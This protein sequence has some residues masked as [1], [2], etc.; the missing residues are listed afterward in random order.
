MAEFKTTLS[1]EALA[2][3]LAAL[4]DAEE[5]YAAE[6]P[7]PQVG[8]RPV[9]VLYGGADRFQAETASKMGA[10]AVKA[11]D[12]RLPDAAGLARVTGMPA[13]LAAA[14]RPRVAEKL[15]REAVEDFRIDFE[16][17]YGPRPDAEE[18]AHAVGA[19]LETAT[20]MSRG[21]LPPFI[22][23][24]VKP[25]TRAD[26]A[27]SSRT[28]DLYLT[29]L[30]KAA[31]GRLPANFVVTLPKVAFPE[32]VLALSDLLERI[33]RAHVLR[34]GSVGVELLIE[35]PTALVSPDGAVAPRLLVEA[36]RGRCVG[37]H[38]GP[39]DMTA[40][41]GVDVGG[42][43]LDH[44]ACAFALRLA[45]AAVS[46]TGVELSD[47]PV[48]TLP[49][50]A[51]VAAID[52]ALGLH[53]RQVRRALNEG[54]HRGWDLHPAQLG[55]RYAAVYAHYLEALPAA[56]ERLTRFIEGR[57]KAVAAGTVFDDAATVRGL[58]NFFQQGLACGA[59]KPAD[60]PVGAVTAA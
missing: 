30:L 20:A 23:I 22:G 44:P 27:R 4:D 46:G 12:E 13:A 32:Q 39:Y 35:T 31:R 56:R 11:F 7:G 43:T 59:L 19:A 15:A 21:V 24:R 33:E 58:T 60:A 28:L 40:S 25:L 9:H 36:A 2:P 26:M 48:S 16:D 17:G 8:R 29:A 41:V 53:Y 50:G 6:H 55:T 52:A 47:G 34:N 57:E 49:L 51:D 1:P 54:V 37:L 38:L 14:V 10:L 3:I 5:N 45:A 42:Q 18:D